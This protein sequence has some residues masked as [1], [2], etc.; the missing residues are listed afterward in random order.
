MWEMIW[1]GTYVTVSAMANLSAV[2]ANMS[3]GAGTASAVETQLT[4]G[5]NVDGTPSAMANHLSIPARKVNRAS[6][7]SASD[8]N[9]PREEVYRL[10]A[11]N[12]GSKNGNSQN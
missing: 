5:S 10:Q 11:S 2:A 4:V 7:M 12:F 9:V 1:G 3:S 8:V 6:R